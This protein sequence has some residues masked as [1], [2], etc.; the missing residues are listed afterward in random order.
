M[1]DQQIPI[2]GLFDLP[3]TANVYVAASFA[4]NDKSITAQRKEAILRVVDKIQS[5]LPATRYFS[6]YLPQT[7]KI[8][9]AWDMSLGEWSFRVYENDMKALDAADL[10]I[11]LSFGKENNSGSVYEC[12]YA[13]AKN[14]PIIMI[15]MV[16]S[17]PESLMVIH[18]VHAIITEEEIPLYDWDAC[19]RSYTSSLT[20]I[21]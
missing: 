10:V 14:K 6:C 19:P 8:P 15:K 21:S 16:P 13:A 2:A 9:H 12:G 11:F 1:N 3:S 4:Y 18:S 17:A 20:S 7:L 5:A